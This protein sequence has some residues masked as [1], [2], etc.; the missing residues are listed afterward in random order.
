NSLLKF[1]R[2]MKT[3]EQVVAGKMYY[4]TLEANDAGKTKVYEAKVWV[5]PWM[6][7]KQLEEF[8]NPNEEDDLKHSPKED[9][10]MK[11]NQR[12]EKHNF[13]EMQ[14]RGYC[15]GCLRFG[16][17][18]EAP[19][20]YPFC[21]IALSILHAAQ[22]KIIFAFVPIVPVDQNRP[23]T[24][25][26]LSGGIHDIS[27]QELIKIKVELECRDSLARFA[28][29]EHNKK[30]NSLLMFVRLVKTKEQLVAGRLYHFTLEAKDAAGKTKVY[31]AK[32]WVQRWINFK[33]LQEFKIYDDKD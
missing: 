6:N 31:R 23:T 26:L 11:H 24:N 33:Q 4:F 2:L 1:G 9:V 3:R 32:V 10:D 25:L 19:F 16:S 20:Q 22:D 21:P 13:G 15:L 12:K 27:E 5:K 17:H 30:T 29:D 7:F 14:S 8:K 18:L 28:V